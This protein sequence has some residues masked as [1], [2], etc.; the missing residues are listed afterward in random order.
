MT[1]LTLTVALVLAGA[2]VITSPA[3]A[4]IPTSL[5][6]D[7]H[8]ARPDAPGG[9]HI[10][11]WDRSAH[12][13]NGIGCEAC[14]GG[15]PTTAE[16]FLAHQGILHFHN[17]ASPVARI[18][19]PHTCGKCHGGPLWAF[20]ASRHYSLLRAGD[21]DVPTCA[22][23]HEEAAAYLLS[24]KQLERRCLECHGPGK[25]AP[26]PEVAAR[27]RLMLEGIRSARALL[28]ETTSIITKVADKERR[29][30]L[31]RDVRLAAEPLNE[32][33]EAG[34]AFVFTGLDERLAL[35]RQ[36]IADLHERLANPGVR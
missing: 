28:K 30:A 34:H 22:T 12:G 25:V 4:Q 5:C 35:A 14:H 1:R 2:V 18:N 32:A 6:G 29:A 16:P 27:A 20:Q 21:R 11:D 19:L 24:P 26:R 15:N 3:V 31:E 23:C 33:T 17:P 36:R 7:C 13:R 9:R 10:A 8:I